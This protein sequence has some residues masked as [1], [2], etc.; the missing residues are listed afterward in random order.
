MPAKT[1]NDEQ[2]QRIVEWLACCMSPS[3]VVQRVQ[4]EFKLA[5]KPN[6][7]LHYDPTTAQGQDL[8]ATLKEIFHVTRQRFLDEAGKVPIAQQNYRLRK[9]QDVADR[10][11]DMG[12]DDMVMRACRQAAEETGGAL[13]NRRE[14]TGKDGEAIQCSIVRVPPKAASAEEWT[15]MAQQHQQ[16]SQQSQAQA[17]RQPQAQSPAQPPSA[18]SP[19]LNAG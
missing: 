13:T 17:Q 4:D 16:Q 5:M 2:Q 11:A 9:L 6:A 15:K 3:A 7:I 8:A 18:A 14:H 1:L 12:N 19:P 10:A